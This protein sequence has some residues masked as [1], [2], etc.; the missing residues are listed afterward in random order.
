VDYSPDT[1]QMTTT[2]LEGQCALTGTTG[3]T[4]ELIGGQ[5]AEIP[6][7]G[8]DPTPPQP[9]TPQELAGWSQEVPE[10]QTVVA[11]ITPEATA[12]PTEIPAPNAFVT[13]E[14]TVQASSTFSAEF[15]AALAVDGSRSTSWFSAGPNVD[16][17]ASTFQWTGV[18][19]D[20]ITSI[21]IL[22]NAQHRDPSVR[23]GFGF[24][25]VTVQILDAAGVVVYE[26]TVRLP[27]T[28]DPDVNLKLGVVGRSVL[29]SFS[30]HE[31]PTCGGFSELEIGVTR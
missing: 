22:S 9:I 19:D 2:C 30:G 3:Q 8:Q 1:G 4:T 15:P 23:T 24:D 29:L 27:G 5:Q 16:G 20:L 13:S 18:Q 7:P 28:P 21:D 14:G 26:E 25:S 17:P 31:D 6:A 10:A 12:T 11:V